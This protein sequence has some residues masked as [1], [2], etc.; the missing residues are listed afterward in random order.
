MKEHDKT[1]LL[2]PLN[3]LFSFNF[4]FHTTI[5]HP[6]MCKNSRADYAL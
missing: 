5:L 2:Y 4:S 6:V 3:V 1:D